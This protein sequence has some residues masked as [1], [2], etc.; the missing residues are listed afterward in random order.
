ML[1]VCHDNCFTGLNF[2][3]QSIVAELVPPPEVWVGKGGDARCGGKEAGRLK[4]GA[5]I[6]EGELRMGI[7]QELSMKVSHKL[8]LGC[9]RRYQNMDS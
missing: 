8:Y 6:L 4:G 2:T 3:I 7:G 9:K 5:K 1:V